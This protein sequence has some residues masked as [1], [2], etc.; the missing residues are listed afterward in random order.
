MRPPSSL[1]H[2]LPRRSGRFTGLAAALAAPS[3]AL[4]VPARALADDSAPASPDCNSV[5]GDARRPP[6]WQE[7]EACSQERTRALEAAWERPWAVE[8]DLGLGTPVGYGGLRLQRAF[9]R[10]FALDV[11][12]GLSA[13]DGVAPQVETMG[14]LRLPLGRRGALDLG[15]GV[16]AGRYAWHE[17]TLGDGRPAVKTWPLAVWG[18]VELGYES[19]SATGAFVRGFVGYG[20]VLNE[21]A[22]ACSP[23]DD[24]DVAHCQQGHRGDGFWVPYLGVG[25]GYAFE[26]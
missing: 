19:R 8:V 6:S 9:G 3:I 5:R 14:H 11:G 23:I 16:S 10:T 12:G 24:G 1:T 26:E 18:N 20:H 21:S 25:V 22:G 4:F 15:V 2:R 7:L 17:I 13:H